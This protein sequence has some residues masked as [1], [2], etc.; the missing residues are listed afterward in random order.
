MP[1]PKD[2]DQFYTSKDTASYCVEK[3]KEVLG[4][5]YDLST[6]T[7]LEPSAGTGS[8]LKALEN[9][10]YSWIAGDIEPCYPGVVKQNFL[11]DY[12]WDIDSQGIVIGNPPFGKRARLAIDFMNKAFEMVDTV[13]FILPIQFNKYLTQKKIVDEA[14]LIHSEILDPQSFTFEEKPYAIRS[15]F[16]IWTKNDAILPDL[17]IRKAPPT[18][19][20]D[21]VCEYYNCVPERLHL[22]EQHW[23]FAVLRQ[24]WEDLTP[25]ELEDYRELSTK[26][27]WMFFAASTPEVKEKLLSID[28]NA[29]GEKNTSVRGFGKADIVEEYTRLFG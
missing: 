9:E 5:H 14:H 19:H 2:L 23:D 4:D 27:Q 12:L 25:I 20:P 1:T 7:F 13:A 6:T 3:V 28:Y 22:F 26:K 21:F 11:E 10:G 16:Q 17:R 18:T 24:G 29:L 15:V 8:F